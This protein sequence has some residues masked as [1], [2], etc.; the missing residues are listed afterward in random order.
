[1]TSDDSLLEFPCE[2]PIKAICK[3]MDNISELVLSVTQRHSPE[4]TAERLSLTLSNGGKYISV[5]IL[6]NAQSR[7][8]IDSIYID[9]NQLEETIMLL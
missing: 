7:E 1:M 8:Q 4:I 2:F 6:L 5:T 9:L 3:N